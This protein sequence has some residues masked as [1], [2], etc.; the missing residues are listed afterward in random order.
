MV[1]PLLARTQLRDYP[2][3]GV[4]SSPT[5]RCQLTVQPLAE[6]RDLRVETAD[7]LASGARRGGS[8]CLSLAIG[9][10]EEAPVPWSATPCGWS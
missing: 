2:I 1:E 9:G 7:A 3:S 5:V 6:R 10:E 8:P 4:V